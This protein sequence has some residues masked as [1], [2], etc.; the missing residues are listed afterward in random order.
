MKATF[1]DMVLGT[2]I[3]KEKNIRRAAANVLFF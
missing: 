1:K 2:M 3:D